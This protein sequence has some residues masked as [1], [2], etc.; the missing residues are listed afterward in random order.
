MNRIGW[1]FV[2]VIALVA[3]VFGVLV[4]QSPTDERLPAPTLSFV[5]RAPAVSRAAF[6]VP[7]AG[8]TRAQLVNSWH[9]VR[10]GGARVHEALDIAA[11]LGTPVIA[12]MPGRVEKIWNSERGGLTVYVRS[13]DGMTMAYYAH[14]ASYAPGLAEGQTVVAGQALGTVGD[15]GNAGPGN[16]HLHFAL[17]RMAP[18]DKWYG[19]MPL[20]PYPLLAGLPSGG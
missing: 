2:A 11:P 20:N 16:T 1:S 13:T 5:K 18:N 14:L 10:E 3:A 12:A 4:A 17:H 6:V 9:D 8:V 7:V 19:G 15:S